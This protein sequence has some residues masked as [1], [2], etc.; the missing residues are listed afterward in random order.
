MAFWASYAAIA[1]RVRKY[2]VNSGRTREAGTG[3]KGEGK[4]E[5]ETAVRWDVERG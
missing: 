4:E 1:G 5:E 3:R 2:G